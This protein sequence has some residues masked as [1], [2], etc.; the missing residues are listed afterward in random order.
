MRIA[1]IG[2]GYVGLTTGACF[3]SLGNN[4]ICLD[5]DEKRIAELKNGKLPFYEPELKE[6]VQMN[7][8]EERLHFT[9]NAEEAIQNS[10]IIFI[11]VGT[12]S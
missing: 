7:S 11:T 5:V 10:D 3:A 1:M 9:T 2:T 12:P 6:M 4:V 8:K